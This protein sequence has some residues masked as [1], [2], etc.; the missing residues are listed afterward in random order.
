M[1]P[2]IKLP[3]LLDSN[4]D[5]KNDFRKLHISD[6]HEENQCFDDDQIIHEVEF[7]N[8]EISE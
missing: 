1:N 7:D 8:Y 3:S 4:V 6:N 2:K 5:L